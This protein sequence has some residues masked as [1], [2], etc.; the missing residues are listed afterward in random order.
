LSLGG[1]V[2]RAAA[3]PL[4]GLAAIR[5]EQAAVV[6]QDHRPA[7]DYAQAAVA[8]AQGVVDTDQAAL[9][10][11]DREEA[12]ASAAAAATVIKSVADGRSLVVATNAARVAAARLT[13][14][15]DRLRAI[16]LALYTCQVTV[17][18]PAAASQPLQPTQDEL[19]GQT[20]ANVVAEM[21]V[22]NVQTDVLAAAAASRTYHGLV[23]VVASDAADLAADRQTAASAA[24]QAVA[25]SA[26]L[27]ADQGQLAGDQEQLA[28][29]LSAQGAAI[30]A[31]AGPPGESGGLSLLAPPALSA[32]QLVA[33]YSYS[34]YV[35]LT[36]AT[37]SQLASWY[38]ADAATE[39][40]R[41]DVA[42]AQAVLETGGFSSPDAVDLNNYAGIGHCDSCASGWAF[43]SP[44]KGVLGQLQL[45]RIFADPDSPPA[46]ATAPVFPALTVANQ[47]RSGCC[48]TWESLTGVWATDPNYGAE[49]LSLYQSMLTFALSGHP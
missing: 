31:L 11:A 49:I 48:G 43:P 7:V 16:A 6:R 2:T 46:G 4:S 40:V 19:F 34:G 23:D 3:A 12:E 35:D 1:V 32:A 39:G 37:I 44:Q 47:D 24:A 21:V 45:L 14:D 30:A 27:A 18:T 15:R 42:F 22:G 8:G 33:W 38:I 28:A 25:A 17:D 5:A 9:T 41:G 29:A 10:R 36:P 13:D 26:D 20:Q